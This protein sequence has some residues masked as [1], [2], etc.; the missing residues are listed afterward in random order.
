MKKTRIEAKILLTRCWVGNLSDE[1]KLEILVRTPIEV[2]LDLAYACIIELSE[3]GL[4][5]LKKKKHTELPIHKDFDA[6]FFEHLFHDWN[7][8][9]NSFIENELKQ[10]NHTVKISDG[11]EPVSRCLCC[12][13]Y[14]FG[15]GEEA[16][17]TECSICEWMWGDK[18]DP[19][20]NLISLEQA[21]HL[22]SENKRIYDK[23]KISTEILKKYHKKG[24]KEIC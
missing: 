14:T 17:W 19:N 23:K 11:M 22:F 1:S 24:D 2:I 3:N 18:N 8:A 12:E 5:L 7:Y 13:Y 16:D 21:K 10:Y 20:P 4:E 9:K 15:V 6:F